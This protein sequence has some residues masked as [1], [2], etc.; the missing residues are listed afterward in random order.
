MRCSSCGTVNEP[1]S[2]FCGSCGARLAESEPPPPML[3]RMGPSGAAGAPPLVD[4]GSSASHLLRPRRGALWAL[5][6]VDAGLAVAGILLLR[7]GLAGE[8]AAAQEE[9]G[10]TPVVQPAKAPAKPTEPR[11]PPGGTAAGGAPPAPA[12]APPPAPGSGSAVAEPPGEPAPVDEAPADTNGKRKK[13][14][15]ASASSLKDLAERLVD[16][17]ESQFVQCLADA[18]R[19]DPGRGLVKLTVTFRVLDD[20]VPAGIKL[21]PQTPVPPMLEPCML[22]V[23]VKWRLRAPRDG[24]NTLVLVPLTV[25]AP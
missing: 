9:V 14:G 8:A 7:A 1:G 17:S 15:K 21:L 22:R 20:G 6:A 23:M 19:I 18:R 11:P 2:R 13:A 5:L 12:P 10:A 3:E 25:N 4:V 24:E 16:K